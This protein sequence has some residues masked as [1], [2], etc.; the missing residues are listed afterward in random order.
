MGTEPGWWLSTHTRPVMA[1]PIRIRYSIVAMLTWT[2]AVILMPMIAITSM[3]YYRRYA[4][5]MM[6]IGIAVRSRIGPP[7]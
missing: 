5:A 3:T 6:S 1:S 7:P 2:R 4:L